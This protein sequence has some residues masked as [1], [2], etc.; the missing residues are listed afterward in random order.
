MQMRPPLPVQ[1]PFL[2]QGAH[3]HNLQNNSTDYA[4]SGMYPNLENP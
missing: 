3:G 4:I 2:A 1:S